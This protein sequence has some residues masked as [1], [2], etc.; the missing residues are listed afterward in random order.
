MR[1][2][3]VTAAILGL[4]TAAVAVAPASAKTR[5][6]VTMTVATFFEVDPNEFTASIPGC[7]EGLTYSA[8]NAAF[9]PPFGVFMGYKLFACDGGEETGFLIRLNARFSYS[10]EGSVGT[11][12]I[13]DAWGDLAGLTGAGRLTGEPMAGGITDRYVGS[14]TL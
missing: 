8:G 4:L 10:G 6:D 12:A 11:W 13:V 5:M 1:R 7:T 14:V 2:F 3:L 9:P